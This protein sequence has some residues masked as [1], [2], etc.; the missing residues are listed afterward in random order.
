M[1]DVTV[2]IPLFNKASYIER[3][4]RSV[5][6]QT[7][8]NWEIVVVDDGSTDKGAEIVQ[9]IKD[10]RIRLIQQTNQGE[11][12]ARNRG[13]KEAKSD[14]ISF[15]DADDDYFPC[16]IDTILRLRRNYPEA[17][18]Y[19]TAY[20]IVESSGK[21]TKPKFCAI[22]PAP[23][24]GIIPNYFKSALRGPPVCS[25]AI[26]VARKV[27][28]EVG[29]FP[30]DEK[31]GEDLDMWLRIAFKYKIAYSTYIGAAYHRDAS[32][33]VCNINANLNGYKIVKT[34]DE[35]LANQSFDKLTKKLL[36]EIKAKK[37]IDSAAQCIVALKPEL[38]Q[39]HLRSC[40]TKKFIF[41]KIYWQFWSYCPSWLLK[42]SLMIKRGINKI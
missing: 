29:C 18:A 12:G 33:R 24:E 31:L 28:N 16:F 25:S 10:Y 39:K 27:F 19:S 21:V 6:A 15:L 11:S 32:N 17:G 14:L 36:L 34:I 41:S 40:R 13:I 4:L 9:S 35:A 8:E 3:A 26:A 7:F 23:W 5:I 20:K 22:P 42:L 2:V 37:I 1:I 30:V 38:A